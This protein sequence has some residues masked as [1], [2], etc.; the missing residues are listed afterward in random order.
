[1]KVLIAGCGYVGTALGSELVKAGHEVWGLRRD[2]DAARSLESSGIK[3]IVANLLRADELKDL[4][5][6]GRTDNNDFVDSK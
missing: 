5:S 3:P 1:M 4:P 6:A 2:V